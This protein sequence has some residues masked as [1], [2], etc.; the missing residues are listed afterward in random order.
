MSSKTDMNDS[1]DLK[2]KLHRLP[3]DSVALFFM[4]Q[5]FL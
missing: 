1:E 4:V 5:F 2:V 3:H